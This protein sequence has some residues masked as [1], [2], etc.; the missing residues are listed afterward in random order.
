MEYTKR[1]PK[2]Q[3][4]PESGIFTCDI[5]RPYAKLTSASKQEEGSLNF[6]DVLRTN[7]ASRKGKPETF[8]DAGITLPQ[9]SKACL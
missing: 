2:Y 7:G 6:E 1:A 4:S 5:W 9:L 8:E 3:R